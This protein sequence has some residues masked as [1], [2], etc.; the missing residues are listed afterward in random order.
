M[1]SNKMI[2]QLICSKKNKGLT[3]KKDDIPFA[4]TYVSFLFQ[5][6]RP[7]LKLIAQL[8]AHGIFLFCIT[9]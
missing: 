6:R 2:E 8:S 5:N 1:R 3:A 7:P 9:E 4:Y